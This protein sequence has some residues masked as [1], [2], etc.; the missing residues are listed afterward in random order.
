MAGALSA[1][2]SVFSGAFSYVKGMKQPPLPLK[3]TFSQ[4]KGVSLARSNHTVSVVNGRAYIFGGE[5]APGRLADNKMHVVYLPSDLMAADYQSIPARPEIKGD[6]V[7]TPRK[8]HTAVVVGDHIYVFG[9]QLKDD[10]DEPHGRL[11]VFSV[12]NKTWKYIDPAPGS[13]F[14]HPR[15]QHASA[16]SEEPQA[17]RAPPKMTGILPQQPPDP[18]KY[19]A[20]PPPPNSWGTIFIYGGRELTDEDEPEEG[21]LLNDAWIFDI[22]SR[23]WFSLPSPPGSGRTRSSLIIAG[24]R[25]YRVGGTGAA[26]ERLDGSVD[27]VEVGAVWKFGLKGSAF[28]DLAKSSLIGDWQSALPDTRPGPRSG[29]GLV[30]LTK[31]ANRGYL[32]QLAGDSVTSKAA[33]F[34]DEVWAYQLPAANTGAAAKDSAKAAANK[35]AKEGAWAEVVY[36]YLNEDGDVVQE[37]TSGAA[38][39]KGFGSRG[40]FGSGKGTEVDGKTAVIWGGIGSN[41]KLLDDGWMITVG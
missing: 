17:D 24:E 3:A 9:G 5:Y 36:Q 7:P 21:K 15:V 8:G 34:S 33:A 20:E 23:T 35:E 19:F 12:F 1:A 18:A 10:V 14:P 26:D 39:V 37:K 40:F 27:W 38:S 11:W 13:S 31:G 4:I 28:G 2:Q 6:T 25:L 30:D 29:A 41:G 32:L 22:R 16:G